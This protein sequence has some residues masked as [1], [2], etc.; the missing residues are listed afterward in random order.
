MF[1]RTSY[2][3]MAGLQLRRI[4]TVMAAAARWQCQAVCTVPDRLKRLERWADECV[5][6]LRLCPFAAPVVRLLAN[7]IAIRNSSPL[8]IPVTPARHRFRVY[9]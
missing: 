4:P 8:H 6:G 5:I 2:F 1:V 9:V 7:F 3:K